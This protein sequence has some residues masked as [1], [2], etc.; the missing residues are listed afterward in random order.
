MLHSD[1]GDDHDGHG[2]L[3]ELQHGVL[4]HSARAASLFSEDMCMAVVVAGVPDSQLLCALDGG[5]QFAHL[6]EKHSV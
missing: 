4:V 3:G 2:C 6:P 5:M 1:V